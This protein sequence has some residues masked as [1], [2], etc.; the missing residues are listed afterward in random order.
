MKKRRS[1]YIPKR[2]KK[3]VRRRDNNQCVVCE[4][5]SPLQFDHIIL[6]GD[7]GDNSLDNIQ[8]LC[9]SCHIKKHYGNNH[10]GKKW[11]FPKISKKVWLQVLNHIW[12]GDL[13]FLG[14]LLKK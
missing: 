11:K 14:P 9:V 2:T 13:Y 3:L 6:V 1:S 10:I 12:K 4:A 7:G 8:L 5:K